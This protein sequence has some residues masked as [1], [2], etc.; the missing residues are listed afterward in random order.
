[1]CDPERKKR[2]AL[3]KE[4]GGER[5]GKRWLR[6]THGCTRRHAMTHHV[7][8]RAVDSVVLLQQLFYRSGPGNYKPASSLPSSLLVC[9]VGRTDFYEVGSVRSRQALTW[10]L[11]RGFCFSLQ[12]LFWPGHPTPWKKRQH[13]N[14]YTLLNQPFEPHS[15]R[16]SCSQSQTLPES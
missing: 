14:T 15:H 12:R 8:Y 1:M 7:V 10:K 11:H 3:S 2:P 5:K 4:G 16:V 9:F 13:N 6:G